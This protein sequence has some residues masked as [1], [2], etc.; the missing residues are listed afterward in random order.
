[1]N[2]ICAI[3]IKLATNQL[4]NFSG[5]GYFLSQYTFLKI[6]ILK[7]NIADIE[8]FTGNAFRDTKKLHVAITNFCLFLLILYS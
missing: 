3:Y 1:M 2:L 7:F 8:N 6:I 4:S 5:V